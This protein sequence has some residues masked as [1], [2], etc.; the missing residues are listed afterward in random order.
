MRVSRLARDLGL[1]V[2]MAELLVFIAEAWHPSVALATVALGELM[3]VVRR[4]AR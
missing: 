3:V 1:L 4:S 2:V